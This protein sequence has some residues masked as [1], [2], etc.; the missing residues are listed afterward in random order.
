MELISLREFNEELL[1][2]GFIRASN[3]PTRAPILFVRTKDSSL[4][5]CI[6]YWG[7][8][9]ITKKKRYPLPLIPNLLDQLSRAKVNTKIEL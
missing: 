6:Y 2:K 3:S 7:L 8:N 4:C 9:K 1:G 5:L